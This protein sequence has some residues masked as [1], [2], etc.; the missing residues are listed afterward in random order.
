MKKLTDALQKE[1]TLGVAARPVSELDLLHWQALIIGPPDSPFADAWFELDIK[2][3]ND[4]PHKP[5]T[6]TFA[7]AMFH[8]N[9]YNDGSICLDI[10]QNMWSP[11]YQLRSVLLSI[12]SLLDNPNPKSPAN[13]DAAKAFDNDRQRYASL[14]RGSIVAEGRHTKPLP[15]WY[16]DMT[17]GAG[18]LSDAGATARTSS[19]TVQSTADASG[20]SEQAMAVDSK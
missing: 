6:V 16:L 15:Q 18:A 17:G 20:A 12:R 14:V 8:P 19:S 1:P 10:L 2:F 4:Y 7:H 5:P 3:G 9:V 11:V 13:V